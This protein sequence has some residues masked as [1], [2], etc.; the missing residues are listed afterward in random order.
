MMDHNDIAYQLAR[1]HHAA[2]LAEAARA[3]LAANPAT[4]PVAEDCSAGPGLLGW[5]RV[6]LYRLEPLHQPR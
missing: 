6:R 2:R 4:A 3:R 5:L 1:L